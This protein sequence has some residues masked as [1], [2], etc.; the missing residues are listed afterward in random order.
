MLI[1]QNT[2]ELGEER[3]AEHF[4]IR[5]QIGKHSYWSFLLLC[6][7]KTS[8]ANNPHSEVREVRRFDGGIL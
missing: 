7:L 1:K 3:R 2:S 6:V 8:F 5:S 4:V